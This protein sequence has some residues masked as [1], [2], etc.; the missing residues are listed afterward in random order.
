MP[1]KEPDLEVTLS[2]QAFFSLHISHLQ[3]VVEGVDGRIPVIANGGSSNNRDSAMNTHTGIKDFWRETGASSVMIA[4]AAEWNPSV[5]R[6]GEK[7]TIMEVIK[8]ACGHFGA[9]S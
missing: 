5:F 8:Q 1:K 4:R 3:R 9:N 7:A 2:H 6:P